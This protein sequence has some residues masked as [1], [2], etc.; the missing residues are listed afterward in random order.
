MM[1]LE[2]SRRASPAPGPE[3]RG[4]EEEPPMSEL[5]RRSPT[6]RRTL[7]SS[8]TVVDLMLSSIG[9]LGTTGSWTV[10]NRYN[11][12]NC[13]RCARYDFGYIVRNKDEK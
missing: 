7:G 2:D 5:L 11:D 9:L 3:A 8:F 4:V 12:E 1:C 10:L 6:E 13:M